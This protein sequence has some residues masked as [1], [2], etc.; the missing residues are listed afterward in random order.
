M[1]VQLIISQHCFVY[2][3]ANDNIL[4]PTL[5]NEFS[6]VKMFQMW[7]KFYWSLFPRVQLT[8]FLE[9]GLS[10]AAAAA[11]AT[12]TFPNFS[13]LRRYRYLKSFLMEDRDTFILLHCSY[14]IDTMTAVDLV[15]KEP[16]HQQTLYKHI[17]AET[18]WPTFRRRH[19]QNA[20]SWMKIDQF[21]LIFHWSLFLRV[22]LTIFQHWFR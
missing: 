4:Q 6:S 16:G 19:F 2:W 11:A 13:T 20:F 21:W 8:A 14:I 12:T 22:E 3:F 5:S 7:L 1:R 17:E 18:K 10:K 9:N 15:T